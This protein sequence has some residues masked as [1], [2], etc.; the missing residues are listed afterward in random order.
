VDANDVLFAEKA[1][2]NPPG[3]PRHDA[4]FG[5]RAKINDGW[6]TRRRREPGHVPAATTTDRYATG[7]AGQPA[8][9]VRM[10]EYRDRARRP[11]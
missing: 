11:D 2:L 3:P 10:A 4:A 7:G 8:R 5:R 9:R 6:E 1:S